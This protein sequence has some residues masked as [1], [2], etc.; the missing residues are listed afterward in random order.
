MSIA[1]WFEIINGNWLAFL[2]IQFGK[3]Y[4][5]KEHKSP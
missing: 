4:E 5:K 1:N 2:H 3:I